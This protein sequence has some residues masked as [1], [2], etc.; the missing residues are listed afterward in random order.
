[1]EPEG[2]NSFGQ[3]QGRGMGFQTNR[4]SRPGAQK[5]NSGFVGLQKKER[6]NRHQKGY[7]SG[8]QRSKGQWGRGNP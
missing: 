1:M 8:A 5:R 7:R 6:N 4:D 3:I 2:S